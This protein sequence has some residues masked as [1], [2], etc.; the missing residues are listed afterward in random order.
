MESFFEHMQALTNDLETSFQARR[1]HLATLVQGTRDDLASWQSAH[2]NMARLLRV[3]FATERAQRVAANQAR[4]GEAQR[5]ADDNRTYLGA[6]RAQVGALRAQAGALRDEA[7]E[8]VACF[9]AERDEIAQDLWT[10]LRADDTVRREATH[11]MIE[12]LV[13]ARLQARDYWNM[14][15]TQKTISFSPEPVPTQEASA[16]PPS[17]GM[18]EEAV[19][20]SDQ[21]S[22]PLKAQ[23]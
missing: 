22:G 14:R 15:G 20:R 11:A 4:H 8:L 9:D 13:V 2:Q 5:A 1:E 10:R 17:Q 16:T 18:A 23:K 3:Q 12:R 21:V 7:R 19:S 6:L